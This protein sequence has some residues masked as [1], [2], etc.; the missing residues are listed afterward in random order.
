MSVPETDRRAQKMKNGV[1]DFVVEST[2]VLDLKKGGLGQSTPAA[3]ANWDS[4]RTEVY[5]DSDG[6]S[7]VAYLV[8]ENREHY[9]ITTFP[10]VMGRGSE[11]DLVLQG[12]GVSRRHAEIIFQSGRFVVNDLESLNGI[13]VNGYKVSRVIL[14]E[15]DT[16]RLGDVSLKFQSGASA[17]KGIKQDSRS[18]KPKRSLLENKS[19]DGAEDAT[20]GP[21]PYKR[22]LIN[23]SLLFAVALCSWFGFQYWQSAAQAPGLV[24]EVDLVGTPQSVSPSVAAEAP[25]VS[26]PAA[27]PKRTD[28][29]AVVEQADVPAAQSVDE[30]SAVAPPPSIA[31]PPSLAAAPKPEVVAPAP[32]ARK[33]DV[34]RAEAATPPKP[35]LEPARQTVAQAPVSAA[36]DTT[37]KAQAAM[38]TAEQDYMQGNVE[39]A[40]NSLKPYMNDGSVSAQV[41][42]DLQ[43]LHGTLFSLQTLYAAGQSSY[44]R[45]DKESAFNDWMTFMQRESNAFSGRKSTYS[46]SIS[47]RVMN[48]YVALGNEAARAGEH[49]KAYRMWQKS[50]EIGDNVAARIA[51]DNANNRAMQLYRQALRLEYVNTSKAKALWQEVVELLP[52]GT[53]YNTKAGAKLAWY[54]KWGT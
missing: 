34:G 2:P 24:G 8:G 18:Q 11:C 44:D 29:P 37:G 15:N 3:D 43:K 31:P 5:A 51:I 26:P 13:K 35:K 30:G 10:F 50:L 46:R 9:P 54:E 36:P 4:D 28:A 41:K 27:T 38:T 47:S 42:S 48:E 19:K 49:H 17:E 53:E 12:K 52:P 23:V 7:S 32:V 20:F 16:V 6:G 40:L 33:P 21:S 14:E 1:E 22:M 25:R 45:G 39:R